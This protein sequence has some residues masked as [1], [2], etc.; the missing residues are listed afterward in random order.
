MVSSFVEP[1]ALLGATSAA[2]RNLLRHDHVRSVGTLVSSS[3]VHQ[4]YQTT[5]LIESIALGDSCLSPPFLQIQK[6]HR[7]S[8]PSHAKMCFSSEAM[9]PL[10]HLSLLLLGCTSEYSD[11]ALAQVHRVSPALSDQSTEQHP[12]CAHARHSYQQ[13]IAMSHSPYF[14]LPSNIRRRE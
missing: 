8:S 1:Q 10:S 13:K 3:E 5:N 14:W 2:L 9:I 7:S 12:A 11:S 4:E 6:N